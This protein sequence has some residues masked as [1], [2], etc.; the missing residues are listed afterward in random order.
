MIFHRADSISKMQ[1][2]GFVHCPVLRPIEVDYLFIYA[3][4][5]RQKYVTDVTGVIKNKEGNTSR[6]LS[7]IC[8]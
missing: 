3:V 4:Y 1:V 2:L 5:Q 7:C 8:S 6:R